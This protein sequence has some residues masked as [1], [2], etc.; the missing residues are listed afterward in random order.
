[1][2]ALGR[3]ALAAVAVAWAWIL[4]LFARWLIVADRGMGVMIEGALNIAPLRPQEADGDDDDDMRPWRRGLDG[5][6]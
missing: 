2:R 5:G 1:M 3:L 6:A 4:Y